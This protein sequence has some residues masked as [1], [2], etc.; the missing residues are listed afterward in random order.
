[1][2]RLQYCMRNTTWEARGR[3]FTMYAFLGQIWPLPLPCMHFFNIRDWKNAWG[4]A[5]T[6]GAYI[7]NGRPLYQCQHERCHNMHKQDSFRKDFYDFHNLVHL[8]WFRFFKQKYVPETQDLLILRIMVWSRKSKNT[9]KL[10]ERRSHVQATS[11]MRPANVIM[12]VLNG[13]RQHCLYADM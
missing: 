12:A 9:L 6:P 7:L 10:W 4:L 1:M 5:P 8:V 11:W 13:S 3:P 2:R